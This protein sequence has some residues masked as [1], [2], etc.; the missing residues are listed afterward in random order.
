MHGR[1]TPYSPV[2]Q[3]MDDRLA[4]L[5]S[6]LS[7]AVGNAHAHVLCDVFTSIGCVPRESVVGLYGDARL[8]LKFL[9]K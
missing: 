8:N 1:R 4:P 7:R 3:R 2:C 5:L 9:L 6:V